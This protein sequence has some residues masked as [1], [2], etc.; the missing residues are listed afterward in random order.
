MREKQKNKE[1]VE[2]TTVS[3][4]GAVQNMIRFGMS[5]GQCGRIG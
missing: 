5:N 4:R 3:V 2:L 1:R